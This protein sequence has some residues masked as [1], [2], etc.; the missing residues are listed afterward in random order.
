MSCIFCKIASSE[1]PAEVIFEDD[2]VLCFKDVAPQAPHHLLVIP[3]QHIGTLEQL[4][5]H[6]SALAGK[7]LFTATQIAKAEGFSSE[8]Y[9]LVMNCNDLGGQTVG[10]IHMHLLGGRQMTWPPG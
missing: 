3:R 4:E 8:G 6:H 5:Q 1:I 7:M 2:E 9:R 10:H